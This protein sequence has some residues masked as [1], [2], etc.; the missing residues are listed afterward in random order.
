MTLKDFLNPTWNKLI[1]FFFLEFLS[2]FVPILFV[3]IFPV[4]LLFIISPSVILLSLVDLENLIP[5]TA[6]L[7]FLSLYMSLSYVITLIY[8]YFISCLIIWICEKIKFR[9][10][11]KK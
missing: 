7:P 11:V 5:S 9:R 2:Q 8:R 4:E 10:K 3:D 1:L 6:S